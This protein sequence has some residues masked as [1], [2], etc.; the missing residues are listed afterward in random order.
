MAY[1]FRAINN[2][3]EVLI[4]SSTKNLFFLSKATYNRIIA[5]ETYAGGSIRIVYRVSCPNLKV[6]LPFFTIPY[7]N[8]YVGTTRITPVSTN[9]WEIELLVSGTSTSVLPEVY[10]FIEYDNVLSPLGKYGMIV[11][12]DNTNGEVTFDSRANALVID[13]TISVTPTSN[14]YTRTDDQMCNGNSNDYAGPVQNSGRYNFKYLEIGSIADGGTVT[15]EFPKGTGAGTMAALGD[16]RLVPDN[17][18]TFPSTGSCF[19]NSVVKPIYCY[20]TAAQIYKQYK[21]REDLTYSY[22]SGPAILGFKETVDKWGCT[23]YA[24][25][26]RTGILVILDGSNY[27]IRLG[28]TVVQAAAKGPTTADTGPEPYWVR[29]IMAGGVGIAQKLANTNASYN[30]VGGNDLAASSTVGVGT[31]A[32]AQ[33]INLQTTNVI[34]ADGSKYD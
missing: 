18:G 9:L 1:G 4:D 29:E 33:S 8:R 13:N 20:N 2:N 15:A 14:P 31:W 11:Y 16:G 25:F 32:P 7:S 12:Q 21:A 17:Y 3:S 30:L 6:P 22:G 10:V 24:T 34:I 19:R 28:W 26:S 27:K 5:T 23:N